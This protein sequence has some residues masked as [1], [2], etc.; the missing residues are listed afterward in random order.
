MGTSVI[1]LRVSSRGLAFLPLLP[2]SR[3]PLLSGL[4][5]AL[6]PRTA[7]LASLQVPSALP[8]LLLTQAVC[9]LPLSCLPNTL[10]LT[11]LFLMV[12]PTHLRIK[13]RVSHLFVAQHV[14]VKQALKSPLP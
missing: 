3:H 9:R 11:L 2:P 14:G 4:A 6:A 7:R 10:S 5:H 1:A 13:N 8:H 12:S